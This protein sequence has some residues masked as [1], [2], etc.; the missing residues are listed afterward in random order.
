LLYSLHESRSKRAKIQGIIE[1]AKRLGREYYALTGRP[2]GVTGEIAEHEAFRLLPIERAPPREP[3]YDA[4]RRTKSGRRIRLQI[5]S[6]CY[7]KEPGQRMPA[8]NL[9]KSWDR[10][11]FVHLNR[12]LDPVE[13]L[14][15]PRSAV[16]RRLKKPGSRARKRGAL[17]VSQFRS[18]AHQLWRAKAAH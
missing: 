18:I 6:R 15:A 16:E 2:L 12:Q 9:K 3:G 8:I 11:L 13:I 14:E 5:K 10:V 17:A 7:D 4:V 1:A